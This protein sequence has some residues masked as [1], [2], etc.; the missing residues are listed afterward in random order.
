MQEALCLLTLRSVLPSRQHIGTHH[1][2]ERKF[3]FKALG[4]NEKVLSLL[5]V[6]TVCGWSQA[7]TTVLT[8]RHHCPYLARG[9]GRSDRGVQYQERT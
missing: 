1:D 4:G 7:H 9:R 5:P 8:V 6:Q 3:L 2:S